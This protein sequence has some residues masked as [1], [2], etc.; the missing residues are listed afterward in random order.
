[1]KIYRKNVWRTMIYKY[2]TWINMESILEIEEKGDETMT[3][4][5]K[6]QC[7][8]IYDARDPEIRKQYNEAKEWAKIYNRLPTMDLEARNKIL[9]LFIGC[10]GK[11]V[12]V[13]QPLFVDYGYNITLGDNCFINMNCTLLDA[14]QIIIGENTLLG[15]DVK[16]YT[17]AHPLNSRDRYW[18]EEDGTVAVKTWTQPVKIGHDTWIGGGSVILPGVEIGNHVVIGAGSVV[19]ESI[20]DYAIAFGNPCQVKSWNQSLEKEENVIK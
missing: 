11:N 4:V 6:K 1:M 17:A 18:K 7:G 9:Q 15:P 3:E 14:G 12:R 5:E 8:Q 19:T 10:L 2:F 13:N 20:P 16:I